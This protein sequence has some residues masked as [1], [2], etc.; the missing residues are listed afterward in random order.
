MQAIP[1]S[2]SAASSLAP[3]CTTTVPTRYRRATST[4]RAACEPS[5]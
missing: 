5:V 1:V 3:I 4:S 2:T